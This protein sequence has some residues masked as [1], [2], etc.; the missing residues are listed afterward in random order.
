MY[1]DAR[2]AFFVILALMVVVVIIWGRAPNTDDIALD[3][4]SPDASGG[5]V[6]RSNQTTPPTPDA[7]APMATRGASLPPADARTSSPPAASREGQ[8]AAP[9][10]AAEPS[11]PWP[12]DLA[13]I[14]QPRSRAT[15]THDGPPPEDP[16]RVA[17]TDDRTT[18][19]PGPQPPAPPKS[20]STAPA[21]PKPLAVHTVAKGD[22]Y[23]K[24]ARKY[25]KNGSKWR[26]IEKANGFVPEKLHIG[27]KLVIPALPGAKPA[28]AARP[29]SPREPAAAAKAAARTKGRTYIV[30]K[31]DNF[32]RI[33]Q[34]QY[35]KAS[36]WR[37][38]YEHN[39]ARL[40][41]PQSPDSLRAGTR[42]EIPNFGS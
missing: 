7:G 2:F 19:A 5:P 15:V 37:R 10:A 9:H 21:K 35:K 11:F 3:D 17:L 31:G 12:A 29:A 26:L 34:R 13:R 30:K 39:R 40:P 23:Q 4:P 18:H 42:I 14:D 25:Y 38:L 24:L 28:T 6:A 22:T 1:K 36:L 16:P 20:A 32:Y 8:R 27:R 41:D 33:A